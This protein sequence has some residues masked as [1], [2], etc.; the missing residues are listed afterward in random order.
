MK[1][2]TRRNSGRARWINL[3]AFVVTA[4]G[5]AIAYR[6][7]TGEGIPVNRLAPMGFVAWLLSGIVAAMIEAAVGPAEKQP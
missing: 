7:S 5:L 3:V 6:L 4:F 1:L 2:R